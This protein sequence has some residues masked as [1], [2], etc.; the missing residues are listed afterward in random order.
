[1][2][3]VNPVIVVGAGRSGTN[4]LRDIICGLPGYATWPCDE[5]NYIWRHGNRT[6]TTDE[7]TVA[8]AR[9]EVVRYVR[10]KF[11]AQQRR[12]HG[13]TVVEKTCA[14]TLRVGFAHRIFPDAR[15][16]V[17]VRDG[18]DVAVSARARWTA[19]VA[20]G[21][22]ARKARFVPPTDIAY[23][24]SRWARSYAARHWTPEHRV[25][26]WGPRFHGMSS[27]VRTGPLIEVCA[28]QWR[29]CVEQADR[30]LADY[31]APAAVHRLSY[32]ALAQSPVAEI[33]RL[34]AFLELDGGR[35]EV[36]PTV[37]KNR[38]GIWR[39]ALTDSELQAVEAAAGPMLNRYG[40]LS[41]A[42]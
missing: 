31:V 28:L 41:G 22:L 23:Y 29:R 30:Q 16:V 4:L 3:E 11:A 7:L 38:I 39:R 5:I 1:M 2:A 18:R 12:V 20:P 21:Y 27:A 42:R 9:P 8:D 35:P 13:A 6:A 25:A 26:S 14:T 34:K 33:D 40:Y 37:D 17:I 10:R 32:E 24:A 15:F 19:G 36:S